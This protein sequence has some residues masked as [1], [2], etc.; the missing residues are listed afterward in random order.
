MQDSPHVSTSAAC[1]AQLASGKDN[2]VGILPTH[3]LTQPV[4]LSIMQPRIQLPRRAAP[5]SAAMLG[6]VKNGELS[7]ECHG[8]HV[9]SSQVPCC[10]A[11]AW[12]S[13]THMY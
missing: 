12:A 8:H 11:A 13:W 10:T 2:E 9:S 4:S 1:C 3:A 7:F 5:S 6:A